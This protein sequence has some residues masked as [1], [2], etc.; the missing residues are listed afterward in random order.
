MSLIT[1]EER[2]YTKKVSFGELVKKVKENRPEVK[3]E[4]A[5]ELARTLLLD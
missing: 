2:K 3:W 5:R 4:Y 1:E